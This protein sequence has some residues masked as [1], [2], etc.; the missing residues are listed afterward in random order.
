MEFGRGMKKVGIILSVPISILHP[1]KF[2]A[3]VILSIF[4]FLFLINIK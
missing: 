1:L 3:P 2:V 4:D